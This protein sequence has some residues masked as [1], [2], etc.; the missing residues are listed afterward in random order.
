L[1]KA[2]LNT[3][4]ANGG[5]ADIDV[6]DFIERAA[7]YILAA[8]LD[9]VAR[10]PY[11]RACKGATCH[12]HD[13][14]APYVEDLANVVDMDAIRS[15]GVRIGIDLIGGAAVQYWQPVIERYKIAATVVNDAV[16]PT[17]RFMTVDWDGK[18]RIDC[19][20]RFAIVP[21]IA[22]LDKFDIAFANDTDADRHGIVCPSAGLMNPNVY[23]ATAI[24]I[25]AQTGRI[26]AR[27][28]LSARPSSPAV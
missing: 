28:V 10:I 8:K 2:A 22:L 18:I 27:T 1:T 19:F 25:C 4:R 11:E 9:G 3:I 13:Y 6:T 20:S 16:D 7:N 14:I 5:P 12:V 15:A 17:F 23:L 24:P 21:L 26:G